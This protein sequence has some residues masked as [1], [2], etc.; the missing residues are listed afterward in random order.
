MFIY[1]K[2]KDL[3][4]SL[5][6][7]YFI[8]CPFMSTVYIF[9]TLKTDAFI[10]LSN[11]TLIQSLRYMVDALDEDTRIISLQSLRYMEDALD[12]DTRIISL[13]LSVN[14]RVHLSY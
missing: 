6:K 8:Q 10:Q 2:E 11:L 9:V 4:V 13:D 3:Q 14:Y 12:G 7:S 5:H 1:L